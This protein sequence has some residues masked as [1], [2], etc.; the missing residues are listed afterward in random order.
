MW[1]DI[2]ISDTVDRERQWDF[3]EDRGQPG[4]CSEIHTIHDYIVT[5]T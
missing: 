5:A 1:V 2:L 3:S 4:L